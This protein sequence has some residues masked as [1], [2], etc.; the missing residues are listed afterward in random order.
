MKNYLSV[1]DL[2]IWIALIAGRVTLCLCILRKGVLRR[3]PWFSV[4]VFASTGESI[5]LMALAFWAS[6][7]AYY[8]AFYVTSHAVSV[9]AF[10]VLIE[11]T[12]H[13]LPGLDL[14]R[15][16]KALT[17]LLA[18]ITA[19]VIFVSVWPLRYLEKRIEV[20]AYLVIAVAFIFTAAYSR[21]LGLRWSRLLGGVAFT[22]GITYLVQGAAKAVIGQIPPAPVLLVRQMSQIANVLAAIAWT[23]IVLSPWGERLMTEEDLQKLE[24]IVETMED[25]VR[26]FVAGGPR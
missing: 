4:Y 11:F 20:G 13:V 25:N 16:E 3:L 6:Y 15:K 17:L 14:P 23:V 9:L 24:Q 21:S 26:D 22:L 10:L 7:A 8:Y 19:V 5:L 2:A 18:S 1:V 12:R